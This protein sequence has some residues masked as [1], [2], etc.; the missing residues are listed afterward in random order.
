[1]DVRARNK[2]F[3]PQLG[4][5]GHVN[6][7]FQSGFNPPPKVDWLNAHSIQFGFSRF[8]HYVVWFSLHIEYT[9]NAHSMCSAKG[10]KI[11]TRMRSAKLWHNGK[12]CAAAI[13][14]AG[15]G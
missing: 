11:P 7:P 4:P 3:L 5:R 1:M 10:L 8:S 2:P 14:H 9:L 6:I 15:G 13:F 12:S